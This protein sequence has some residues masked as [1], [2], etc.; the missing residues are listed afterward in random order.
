MENYAI[1]PSLK[2][3]GPKDRNFRG[4]FLGNE[5]AKTIS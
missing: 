4:F 2:G 5:V 1:M 3:S